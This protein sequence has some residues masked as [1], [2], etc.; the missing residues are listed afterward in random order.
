M[1]VCFIEWPLASKTLASTYAHNLTDAFPRFHLPESPNIIWWWSGSQRNLSYKSK[2]NWEEEFPSFPLPVSSH[3]WED[4][5]Y[6]IL[7]FIN[8]AVLLCHLNRVYRM[9]H[10]L[11]SS[12]EQRKVFNLPTS[13]SDFFNYSTIWEIP[14]RRSPKLMLA[15]FQRSHMLKT[16]QNGPILPTHQKKVDA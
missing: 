15:H 1:F 8:N 6:F 14:S 2:E 16:N 13:W 10:F 5:P 3:F 9:F 4:V 11:C 12:A 7:F